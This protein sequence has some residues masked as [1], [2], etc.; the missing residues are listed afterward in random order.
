[1][2]TTELDRQIAKQTLKNFEER[3]GVAH[4]GLAQYASL[5]LILTP[6]LVG[7][8]RSR[9]LRGQVPWIAEADLLLSDLCRQ[10]GYERF[11]MEPAIRAHLL[12]GLESESKSEVASL[13]LHYVAYLVREKRYLTEIEL[14]TQQWAA[15]IYINDYRETA[16]NQIMDKFRQLVAETSSR[17]EGSLYK[18]MNRL[19]RLVKEFEPQLLE[20]PEVLEYAKEVSKTK[21]IRELKSITIPSTGKQVIEAMPLETAIYPS[22]EIEWLTEEF[23]VIAVRLINLE[24]FTYE[25]RTLEA[26]KSH[27]FLRQEQTK[28]KVT[29]QR[30]EGQK[31][32]EQLSSETMLEMVLIPT[33]SFIMGAP[34]NEKDSYDNERPQH[35]VSVPAFLMGRYPITQIQWRIV[36]AMPQIERR[37]D[38]DPSTFKGDNRPVETVSWL[39]VMEFHARLS[40]Y[41]KRKYRLPSEAEWEYACRA[42]T[43]TAYSFGDD[44]AELENYAWYKKNSGDQTHPVGEKPPNAFG[45]YDMHGNVW[46]WCEDD[47]QDSYK[48]A[49][50]DG[51]ARINN[52]YSQYNEVRKLLRGGS[53]FFLPRS[54]RSASRDHIGVRVR[55]LY[56]GFRVVCRF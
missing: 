36:A 17:G 46:E 51:R 37:L 43:S 14:E 30:K 24:A 20:Y 40:V 29:K 2:D 10:V 27:N 19:A 12:G 4:L 26:V 31:L 21:S 22:L 33:G 38:P 5:P 8:L 47:W 50:K 16:V 34:K 6:E 54:C 35:Q 15:M 7:F 1:M 9:F 53:F 3:F 56:N 48:R 13:L 25:V 11:V 39:D 55:S 44:A 49:L 23:E 41:T 52:K 18:E 42:G 45:L 28:N 32:V